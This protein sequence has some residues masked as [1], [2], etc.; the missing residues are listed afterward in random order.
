[1]NDIFKITEISYN[2]ISNAYFTH[3]HHN[4]EISVI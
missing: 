2:L 4:T 3:N 1:M